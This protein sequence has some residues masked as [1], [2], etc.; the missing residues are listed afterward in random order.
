M[1]K[2]C[3][4]Y[5]RKSKVN[6]NS[7]S[8]ETQIQMCTDYLNQQFPGCIIRIYDN[9]YG[10]TGHSIKKRKDFQRMMDDVRAGSINI[11]AIQ[12]YDRIARNTRDFCNIYH[13]MEKVGCE[14]IS[15]SQRIDTST[16]YGKKFMYDLASTAELEW[17][18]NSERHKDV[19]R[20]AR[21]NGKCSISPYALP[22][23]IKAEFING[24]R[25]AV[26]DKE[27][28][29]IVRDM[30]Q[31][32]KENKSK[33]R[34]VRY[35]NEKYNLNKSHSLVDTL[36]RSDF[37]H[38][39]YRE[40]P[41][42]CEAYMTKEEHQELRQIARNRLR[43][44]SDDKNYFL[45]TGLCICPECGLKMESQSQVQ[46]SGH[47]YHYYRC[48]A[49]YR[50]GLCSFKGNINERYIE[51]YLIDN[52]Q[53]ILEDYSEEIQKEQKSNSSKKKDTSKYKQ[54]LERLNTMFLKGRID[55]TTYD[56]EY[57]RL[58]RIILE[59]ESITDTP[60]RANLTDLR[61][62]FTSGWENTYN[63]LSRENKRKF[64]A[65]IIRE[66]HFNQ[67]RTVKTVY[68]L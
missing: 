63:A 65:D 23:G 57:E 25:V 44:H 38:G 59:N 52:I 6:D 62:L 22:F 67:D 45:F 2:V 35:I 30:I 11:V 7:D 37:Y 40:V 20:Y 64:W 17:A 48:Y 5:V 8:M 49:P 43:F 4:I 10:I 50:T 56:K 12:R 46:K 47:R 42:Y 13:D 32:Y 55:E 60:N 24:K 19:N 26:I 31:Y 29:P 27:T 41:D 51:S 16:P 15:V 58:Q 39:E 68:L 1:V 33:S 28:E 3:A 34:T 53:S 66:I 14:L 61:Q 36:L 18:L 21:L 9:D 54:E